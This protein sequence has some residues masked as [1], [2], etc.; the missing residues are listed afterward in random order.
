MF[1]KTIFSCLLF[2]Y[3]LHSAF[4][5]TAYT[6]GEAE[7]RFLCT[8]I[9]SD[10]E[11]I[12]NELEIYIDLDK[13]RIEAEIPMRSFQFEKTLNSQH[14]NEWFLETDKYPKATFRGTFDRKIDPNKD[15]VYSGIIDGQL[16]VKGIVRNRY[17]PYVIT[18]KKG[19]ISVE[20]HFD[21]S[22]LE[23][24]IDLPEIFRFKISE[25]VFIHITSTLEEE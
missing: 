21:V 1:K 18:I 15:G 5:L 9:F 7:I 19:K 23:Y 6:Q 17:I 24:K 2:L 8:G 10:I 25:T 12:S 16:V 20:S 11:G 14:F 22:T 13:N 3:S 4:A